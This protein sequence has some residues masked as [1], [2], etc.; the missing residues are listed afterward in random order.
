MAWIR[1]NAPLVCLIFAIGAWRVK[2]STEQPITEKHN[3]L[4]DL[5]AKTSL[6]LLPEL[7]NSTTQMSAKGNFEQLNMLV[8]LIIAFS[9]AVAFNSGHLGAGSATVAS[10]SSARFS[11][12]HR[13]SRR[14]SMVSTQNI[15]AR[16]GLRSQVQ[17]LWAIS[18]IH[19]D[20]AAN[21]AMIE[22]LDPVAYHKDV[23]IVAGDIA[24]DLDV[25]RKTLRSLRSKFAF[26]FFVAG[27]HDLWVRKQKGTDSFQKL[28]QLD[29]IC[30]EEG[31]E[32]RPRFFKISS[33][34]IIWIVPLLSW[35]CQ[36]FDSEM[37]GWWKHTPKRKKKKRLSSDYLF[38]KW[39]TPFDQADDSVASHVDVMNDKRV[40]EYSSNGRA[41]LKR[42]FNGAREAG[43]VV[44]S[45]SHF[46][47]RIEL[48]PRKRYL[49]RPT[50]AKVVGSPYLGR[51]LQQL[52]PD[53]HVFGHSHFSW[54]QK[55]D[56]IR[57][58]SPAMGMRR[59]R[60]S[61]AIGLAD[62]LLANHDKELSPAPMWLIWDIKQGFPEK[63]KTS[64]SKIV[65]LMR[66]SFVMIDL[67]KL[68][69][70][71]A[72]MKLLLGLI[73]TAIGFIR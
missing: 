6:Q 67:L 16:L 72:I 63:Y 21:L 8:L 65:M 62:D 47:P 34:D 60:A 61:G 46:L 58:I 53:V 19:T 48:L 45:F 35:H 33:R 18:D 9:P 7:K 36:N 56:G 73:S 5:I 69:G 17:R 68:A 59:D 43:H 54:D 32:T 55:L 14:I 24:D 66:F 42:L 25:F 28:Q 20:Y 29:E 11:R 57:Y 37:D 39:P 38:C 4:N 40:L 51:R 26:V 52:R 30:K 44:I 12:Q 64:W 1:K 49:A 22:K 10:M 71:T 23:L 27:N 15:K 41:R 13:F 3:S 2:A 70:V 31:V 50:L